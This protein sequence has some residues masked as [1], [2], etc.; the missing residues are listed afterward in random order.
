MI[1]EKCSLKRQLETTR[2]SKLLSWNVGDE[3]GKNEVGEFQ[4]KL[5]N[6]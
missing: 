4:P 3:I 5:E 1:R 6:F 2:S